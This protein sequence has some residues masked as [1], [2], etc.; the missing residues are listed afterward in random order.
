M[1]LNKEKILEIVRYLIVGV[2]TTVVSL[3]IYYGLVYTILNPDNPIMLQIANM[4]SWIISVIFAYITNR[5]FVFKSESKNKLKEAT[6][7]VGSR[8]LTLFLDMGIMFLGVT[9]LNKN[10][11]IMKLISQ[12]LVI[13]L[14][15]ILS[16]LFVFKKENKK[17]KNKR[18]LEKHLPKLLATLPI[19]EL[20]E[21]YTKS[22]TFLYIK[23]TLFTLLFVIFSTYLW[24]KK[25]YRVTICIMLSSIFLSSLYIFCQEL[26]LLEESIFFMSI[27]LGLLACLYFKNFQE[28][29]KDSTITKIFF[30]YLILFFLPIVVKRNIL[31]T[32]EFYYHKNTITG[33]LIGFLP[34]TIKTLQIHK[35]YLAK[36]L[37]IFL[38][39]LTIILWNSKALAITFL[40]TIGYRFIKERKNIQSQ[41]NIL[42]IFLVLSMIMVGITWKNQI[43]EEPQYWI[44]TKERQKALE[45]NWEK[46][47]NANIE[48]Q[49]FGIENRK[50][51]KSKQINID[52]LDIFY[53]T[54]II[55]ISLYT[56]LLL[57]T[58]FQIR[59]PK[60]RNFVLILILFASIT[61]GGILTSGYALTVLSLL[62]IKEKERKKKILI[63]SN[64]YPS[65]RYK[66][67]GIFVKNTKENLEALGFEVDVVAKKKQDTL[68]GKI[69]GYSHMY[70]ISFYKAIFYSYE[71][72]FVH[73]ITHSTYPVIL[74]KITSKDTQLVLNVHGNDIVPDRKEE[75]KNITKSKQVL[76]YANIVISPS[77]YF[78]D[79]LIENYHIEKSKIK[80]YPSGGVDFEKFVS[81]D[82]KACKK[83]LQLDENTT[84]YGYISRIEKDKGWD[85]LLK[86]L[87]ILKKENKLKN[88]KVI[89][90]GT[91]EEQAKFNESIK[92]YHLENVII[93]KEF[94]YQK[95]LVTY[96]NAMDLF[97]YPTKR[98][99]ES[100]GVVGLEAM[101][102]KTFVI[103]CTLYGPKEYLKE[104]RNALTF[105]KDETGNIL[106]KKIKEFQKMKEEEK[107]DI[108]ENAYQDAQKYNKKNLEEKLKTVFKI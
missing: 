102:C 23:L 79:I 56:C 84:Y 28:E 19:L 13:V 99:S 98:K 107:K 38:I 39:L 72:I 63:V 32:Q 15:Y 9:I 82:K 90:V 41:K 16:K 30:F 96:C 89:V 24:K 8:L 68:I 92:E 21:L 108:I 20:V 2:L 25:E 27:Y 71:Y 105:E 70:L 69:I 7:F 73:F 88:I 34:I 40:I 51:I 95:D 53:Q 47:K 75:E 5:I 106:A 1:S 35:N 10:D 55:G 85:T 83:E 77:K 14:N 65:K 94:V 81:K 44:I 45:E 59:K 66:H 37:G 93:Q 46:F 49:L 62:Q 60:E 50:E 22:T 31:E 4:I 61:I 104:K 80:I 87:N 86:A 78:E 58:L 91:G 57:F 12:V 48:E 26:N 33:I 42:T 97:I 100:L 6:S 74:G 11:K 43:Q 18:N 17:E 54:G 101:A 3:V 29:I 76:P 64:M 36:T 52:I 103:G 67:Y